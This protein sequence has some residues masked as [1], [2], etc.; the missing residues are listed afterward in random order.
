VRVVS[1]IRPTGSLH[2]GNYFGAVRSWVRLQDEHDC[3]YAIADY[4]ALTEATGFAELP[5]RVLDLAAELI[6]CGVDP[7]RSTLFVQSHVPEHAELAWILGCFTAVGDL[8][9]MTQ[10]KDRARGGGPVNAGLLGYPVLQAADVLLYRAA[11]VPVGDDQLQHLELAR[12]IAR[13]FN[14]A[15][16]Q[17]LFGEI[18]ALPSRAGRVMSPADP[19]RKMSKSLG[20]RHVIGVF[21]DAGTRRRT[22]RRA[23]TDPGPAESGPGPGAENLLA[24]LRECDLEEARRLDD[25]LRAGALGYQALKET[26]SERLDRVLVPIQA[27]RR[28]LSEREVRR[29]LARGGERARA[30]AAETMA[31]VRRA[32]GVG[33]DSL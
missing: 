4:H 25:S 5:R 14:R 32:L 30:A 6:A 27:R 33:V 15:V 19:T 8:T 12:S 26:V 16:G 13:R 22:I 9:R 29:A 28:G 21:D 23:V 2:L 31:A 11:A 7:A 1:G 10:Y 20:A 17:E 24:I 3:F 18:A